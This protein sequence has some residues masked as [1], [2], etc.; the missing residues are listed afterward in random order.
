MTAPVSIVEFL[1]ARLA[2]VEANA[3]RIHDVGFC[4]VSQRTY[5]TRTVCTCDEQVRTRRAAE[6]T[7]RIMALH[8]LNDEGVYDADGIERPGKDCAVCLDDW[9]CPTVRLLASE[10]D[11]PRGLPGGVEALID[12]DQR[13]LLDE[14][15][16]PELDDV[17]LPDEPTE[18]RIEYRLTGQPDGGYPCY[19]FTAHSPEHIEDLRRIWDKV[20]S[21]AYGWTDTKLMVR[22]VQIRASEWTEVTKP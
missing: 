17:A 18:D 15:A 5:F 12:R 3:H 8:V 13:Q 2:V 11:H 7:R 19:D 20:Q 22:R 14:T 4:P 21:G 6:A 1:D 16:H 10:F 9:P